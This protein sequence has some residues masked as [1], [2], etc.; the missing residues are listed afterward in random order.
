MKQF[1]KGGV[2]G[3][4]AR[5]FR[6]IAELKIPLYASHASF[7]IA[8]SVFPALV[9]LLGLLRYTGLQVQTLIQML[10]G[11]FPKALLPS[12]ERLIVNTYK[13]TSGAVLSVS[14]ITALWSA[15]RGIHGV[16]TGLNAIYGVQE[17]RSSL[18]T[19]L[20]SVVYTFAFLLVLLLTLLLHVFG[21]EIVGMLS[22]Q[23]S[24]VVE[25]LKNLVDLRI[26]LPLVQTALF[27]A[28]FMVMPNR[29]NRLADS[30]PGALLASVGWLTFSDLYSWYVEHF[31]ALSNIY[32]SVY[33][34][35]LSLLWLYFCISIVFYGGALNHWLKDGNLNN[36]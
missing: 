34:V 9:L 3:K 6:W 26:F 23:G 4:T 12:V 31:A 19:R 18:R 25:L 35:A 8:L 27:T 21:T 13:G 14:A 28:M 33:A 11:L 10:E 29:R 5:I 17:D 2:I 20:L 22:G 30:L 15:S 24:P 1:P 7:F 36:R 16:L 32:G